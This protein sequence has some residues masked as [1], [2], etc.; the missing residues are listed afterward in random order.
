[1]SRIWIVRHGN[2][3]EPDETPRRIGAR[4][5]VP[6]VESGHAQARALAAWFASEGV[7][8]DRVLASPLRRTSETAALIAGDS[9]AIAR[10]DWLAEIDHGPDENRP[11]PEVRERIGIAALDAWDSAATPPPGWVIDAERRVR[12]WRSLLA[13]ATGDVLVVTSNG[14]GRFVFAADPSLV[15][16]PRRKLRTGAFGLI[17]QSDRAWRLSCWDRRP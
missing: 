11:E 16:P 14:A 7:R 17:E 13:E 12:G 6:L 2:T 15:A 8:F 4:T 9:V 1:M 10:C 3:F 5:D